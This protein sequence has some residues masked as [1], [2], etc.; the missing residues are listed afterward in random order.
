MKRLFVSL[1]LIG[2]AA[3]CTSRQNTDATNSSDSTASRIESGTSTKSTVAALTPRLTSIG[4]TTDHD[5]RRV[6]IGD[7]FY[8]AKATETT[9]AFE[10]DASHIGYT[11]E[12]DNLES[13]DYQYFQTGGKLSK[14]QVDLYLNTAKSVNDYLVDLVLYL[15]VRYG[16]AT[17]I[18]GV[19]TW[20]NGKVE[21]KNVS[22]G[23]DFGLKLTMK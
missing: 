3:A 21:L 19:A 22:K 23:K 13:I 20:Q 8:T 12:F 2:L 11:K 16:T 9:E 1:C 18:N 14:I 4:L 6:S 10:Q 7:D 15:T 17:T 5:W